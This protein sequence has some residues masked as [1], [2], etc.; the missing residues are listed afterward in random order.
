[1][2][3]KVYIVGAGPG[4]YE[5]LTLKALRAIRE[6]DVVL[7]DRLVG[8]GI[9]EMI[10]EMGKTAIYVGKEKGEKGEF[11]QREINRLMKEYADEGK[12]VVRLKGGDPLIFGRLADEV[13]FL[14]KNGIPFEVI[15]GVS[16]V[17][18][19]PACANIPLTHP[20]FGLAVVVLTGRDAGKICDIMKLSTFVVLMGGSSAREVALGMIRSGIDPETGVAIIQRGTMEDQRIEFST[21]GDVAKSNVNY[22]SP[23]L[24][25][26]GRVV[27]FVKGLSGRVAEG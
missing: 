21:L 24:M 23:A 1:M 10:R 20:E 7:Y 13:E 16:S 25:V 12:I 15:P 17:N 4:D 9:V 2:R 26:V 14:T 22:E 19:V 11:R 6:A 3:G 27:N 18:G 8:R 5:L